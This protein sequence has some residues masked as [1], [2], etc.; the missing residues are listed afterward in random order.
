MAKVA[1]PRYHTES[2]NRAS[3]A[4]ARRVESDQRDG[5]GRSCGGDKTGQVGCGQGQGLTTTPY[6]RVEQDTLS[7][8]EPEFSISCAM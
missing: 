3:R 2:Y 1:W 6:L 4:K 5:E 8:V 7:A